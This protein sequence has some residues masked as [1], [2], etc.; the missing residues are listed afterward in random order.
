MDR[1]CNLDMVMN[2]AGQI[3][4][5]SQRNKGCCGAD[6]DAC[7]C[8]NCDVGCGGCGAGCGGCG[9]DAGACGNCCAPSRT[10]GRNYPGTLGSTVYQ[11][12]IYTDRPKPRFS[13]LPEEIVLP[14]AK[15]RTRRRPNRSLAPA[16]TKAEIPEIILE[17]VTN[18]Q[19]KSPTRPMPMTT[20]KT[21]SQ[22]LSCKPPD[23]T[24]F[25]LPA[26]CVTLETPSPTITVETPNLAIQCQA[27]IPQVQQCQ[28]P[29]PQ[30]QQ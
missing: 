23:V 11:P 3:L 12:Y 6:I 29:P 13:P 15:A 16:E 2:Q 28:L 22:T 21:Q 9:V 5:A 19:P 17:P 8:A 1:D 25:Q 7:G 24:R 30:V 27:P 14:E 26:P 10:S 18:S 4:G 20:Y